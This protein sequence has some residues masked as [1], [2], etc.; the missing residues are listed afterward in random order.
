M[1]RKHSNVTTEP[2]ARF[3][4]GFLPLTWRLSSLDK[5]RGQFHPKHHGKTKKMGCQFF[6]FTTFPR[7]SSKSIVLDGCWSW[8]LIFFSGTSQTDP[9]LI[10]GAKNT[11]NAC[12]EWWKLDDPVFWFAMNDAIFQRNSSK[13]MVADVES[14][15]FFREVFAHIESFYLGENQPQ[16]ILGKVKIRWSG[17]SGHR[18]L[19]GRNRISSELSLCK[20]SWSLK[21]CMRESSGVKI[22]GME[23]LPPSILK[24]WRGIWA[25]IWAKTWENGWK[26]QKN[27]TFFVRMLKR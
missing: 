23:G 17:F 13:S 3:E 26:R 14:E 8:K 10:I 21:K 25:H 18:S 20:K 11:R 27:G 19:H 5:V 6:L 24:R 7:K 12:R 22:I 15:F 1:G 2:F 16:C 4:S 9:L